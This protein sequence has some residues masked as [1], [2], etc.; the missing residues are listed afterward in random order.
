[1]N[2]V[3]MDNATISFKGLLYSGFSSVDRYMDD[4]VSTL[5]GSWC[6]SFS[7]NEHVFLQL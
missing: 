2:A 7:V 5:S 1:M 6:S 4:H 3:D